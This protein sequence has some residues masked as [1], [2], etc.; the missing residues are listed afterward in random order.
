MVGIGSSTPAGNHGPVGLSPTATTTSTRATV[1]GAN[2]KAAAAITLGRVVLVAC[3]LVVVTT[4]VVVVSPD[5]VVGGEV[6]VLWVVGVDST[7]VVS[8]EGVVDGSAAVVVVVVA[9]C[10]EVPESLHAAPTTPTTATNAINRLTEHSLVACSFEH[11]RR[12]RV[13]Y[14]TAHSLLSTGTPERRS[15]SRYDASA[16][17][18]ASR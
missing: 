11:T 8:S 17:A 14:G 6:V 16:S 13:V 10:S 15:A 12:K 5:V 2:A 7:G 1:P 18:G 3:V 4:E 9:S